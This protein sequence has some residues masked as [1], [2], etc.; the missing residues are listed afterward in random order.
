MRRV[1]ILMLSLVAASPAV[2][3]NMP[4]STF[5]AK[6]D[7]LKA[8][9]AMALFSSDVGLI[10]Q[11]VQAAALSYR[12]DRKASEA[13]GKPKEVCPPEKGSMNS[14]EIMNAFR[15]VPEAARPRTTVKQAWV[16]YMKRKYPCPK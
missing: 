1:F 14:D 15:A 4:V 16:A 9:G 2:A 6:A 12:N 13:A 3:Q 10:K 5:L 8:K 7:A 11:E